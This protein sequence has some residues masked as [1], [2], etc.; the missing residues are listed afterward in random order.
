[1]NSTSRTA[2]QLAAMQTPAALAT[3]RR[4][5]KILPGY[6]AAKNGNSDRRWR[7]WTGKMRR[8]KD[9][10][11]RARARATGLWEKQS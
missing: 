1:M 10:Y 8:A 2:A 5:E 6:K 11:A 4:I 9:A 7:K 3:A